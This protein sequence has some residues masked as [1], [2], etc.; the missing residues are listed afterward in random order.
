MIRCSASAGRLTAVA[1]STDAVSAFNNGLPTPIRHRNRSQLLRAIWVDKAI[2]TV[3]YE[4]GCGQHGVPP[5]L[6]IIC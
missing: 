6:A 4:M 3:I 5:S 2:L 1:P